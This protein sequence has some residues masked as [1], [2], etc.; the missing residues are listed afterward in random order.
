[1]RARHRHFNPRFSGAELVLDSRFIAGV[2]NGGNCTSWPD[3]SGG[4]RTP[5]ESTNPPTWNQSGLNGSAV[6]QFDGTNDQLLRTSADNTLKTLTRSVL[7]LSR[8]DSTMSGEKCQF[9]VSNT[10]ALTQNGTTGRWYKDAATTFTAPSLGTA[11]IFSVTDSGA[12]GASTG[13]I[14]GG[15]SINLGTVASGFV[16]G[17]TGRFGVGSIAVGGFY[18]KGDIGV[19]LQFPFVLTNSNRKRC[20][21]ASAYSFKIT[22]S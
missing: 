6:V 20:E 12:N 14:D 8:P 4:G 22:C 13:F 11:Y 21:H 2:S 18:F 7:I 15:S 10:Y 5:T 19:V 17:S 3:R 16:F 1:M 9:D